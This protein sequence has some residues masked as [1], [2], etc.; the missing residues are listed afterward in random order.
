VKAFALGDALADL[1]F[2]RLV[3]L[4]GDE[5][6]LLER[7][8]AHSRDVLAPLEHATAVKDVVCWQMLHEMAGAGILTANMP[9]RIGGGLDHELPTARRFAII[10]RG[11]TRYSSIGDEL[12]V[13][14]NLGLYPA[15]RWGESPEV[16]EWVAKGVRGE[17]LF[18]YAMT[19]AAAGSDPAGMLTTAQRDGD[20]WVLNGSKRFITNAP[21]ADA[22]TVFAKTD[23][24]QGGR[25]ISA[26]LVLRSDRGMKPGALIGMSAPHPIGELIFDDCHLPASR[27][28]GPLNAGLFIGLE[29]LRIFRISVA[30]QAVGWIERALE[31]AAPRVKSRRTFG[32]RLVDHVGI[33]EK[34]ARVTA[35]LEASNALVLIAATLADD[36]DSDTAAKFSSVAKAYCTEA[37]FEAAFEAQ[38]IWGAEGLVAGHPLE[39]LVRETRQAIMYEGPSEIQRRIVGRRLGLDL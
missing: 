36:G 39:A 30:A 15:L 9:T 32:Q 13:A 24:D 10:R 2:D 37:A 17:A 1:P 14:H 5:E 27:M 25:G 7:A 21:D 33:Q 16:R 19:E 28:L 11:L 31:L 3:S 18:A 4:D 26:F 34:L 6:A 35:R 29:T 8:T 20:T 23:A 12:Y 22:Y 38:Q